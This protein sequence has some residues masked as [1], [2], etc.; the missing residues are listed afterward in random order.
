MNL[1][2]ALFLDGPP[3]RGPLAPSA[4]EVNMA[5]GLMLHLVL[6]NG[7]SDRVLAIEQEMLEAF[8]ET[9]RLRRC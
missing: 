8:G 6:D 5:D 3:P 1:S 4:A 9:E 2:D 7:R